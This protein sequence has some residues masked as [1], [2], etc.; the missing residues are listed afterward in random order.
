M[1]EKARLMM[2]KSEMERKLREWKLDEKFKI[3]DVY[4]SDI[5]P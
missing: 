2:L 1:F 3:G 5:V 4:L